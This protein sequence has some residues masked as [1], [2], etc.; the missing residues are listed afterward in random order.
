M[1]ARRQG[2][3]VDE[4][5]PASMA[6]Q[7]SFMATAEYAAAE[8]IAI[9]S[10]VHNEVDTSELMKEALASSRVLLLP[11][12]GR[13]RLEFRR[14]SAAGELKKGAYGILEPTADCALHAAAGVDLVVIP[15]VAFD[16]RGR[17]IGYG[18]GYYDKT[19]HQ[20]EGK[21]RLVGFCYDFQLVDEIAH[22]PHDVVMDMVVTERRVV[23]A[24]D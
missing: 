5:M 24:T 14:V 16:L 11:K 22:E 17:R 9:Y 21:G 19:L 2:L 18:K 13:D 15:G 23:R 4:A 10:P 8:V 3:P 1:L 12:V 7:R 6:V 20:L